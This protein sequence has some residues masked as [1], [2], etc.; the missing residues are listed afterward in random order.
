[1]PEA[2]STDTAYGRLNAAWAA[3]VRIA[4]DVMTGPLTLFGAPTAANHAATKQY[5]DGRTTAA[6]AAEFL[7]N[8]TATKALTPAT[9]WGAATLVTLTDAA[10][11][12]PDFNTG[13]DFQWTL[14]A[15]GRTLANPNNAK[16]GQKGA[17]YLVQDATGGRSITT[18]GSA[19]KF[20]GGAKPVL[21][22]GAN[23]IDTLTYVVRSA[24]EIHC[25]FSAGMS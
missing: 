24:T 19:W 14:G 25:S 22:G 17:I 8:A 2:P 6:T 5:V 20:A 9:I 12:T 11:V 18:W 10:T 23:A 13:I 21:T 15:A 1:V 7:A 16:V 3:V 4:G